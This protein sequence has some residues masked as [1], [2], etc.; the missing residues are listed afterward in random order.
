[1]IKWTED[2]LELLIKA[3]EYDMGRYGGKGDYAELMKLH[4]NKFEYMIAKGKF[5]TQK[6]FIDGLIKYKD[7]FKGYLDNDFDLYY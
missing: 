3:V 6:E 2:A 4:K 5:K 1:M 7:I